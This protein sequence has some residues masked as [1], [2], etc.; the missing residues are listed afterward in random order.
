MFTTIIAIITAIVFFALGHFFGA[1]IVKAFNNILGR[2][3]MRTVF[4]GARDGSMSIDAQFN[5]LFIYE[6]DHQYQQMGSEVYN[7]MADDNEKIAIYLYDVLSGI[8][9][10]FLP[11]E[12]PYNMVDDIAADVPP[13][14][15]RGG[16]EVRQVVDLSDVS[17]KTVSNNG[18][19]IEKG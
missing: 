7:P 15:Y 11:P 17:A 3:Y 9:D 10:D 13:M 19:D 14:G 8:A 18:I 4:T 12:K 2:P 1:F 16:D 5:N 6:L